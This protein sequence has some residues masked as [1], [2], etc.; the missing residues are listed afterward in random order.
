[1]KIS[2]KKTEYLGC[3]VVAAVIRGHTR[4]LSAT[5]WGY[6]GIRRTSDEVAIPPD[7]SVEIRHTFALAD[8][9]PDT[10]GLPVLPDGW[11]AQDAAA[12]LEKTFVVAATG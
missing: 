11:N 1:M 10:I 7:D 3:S 8:T 12:H 4:M 6:Q 2:R 9:L 5:F